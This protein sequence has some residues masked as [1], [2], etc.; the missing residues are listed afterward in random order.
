MIICV[1]IYVNT[2]M[3]IYIYIYIHTQVAAHSE[4]VEDHLIDRDELYAR[5]SHDQVQL[6][7]IQAAKQRILDARARAKAKLEAKERRK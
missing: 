4:A 7:G 6:A 1:C 3:I 5:M 2:Y